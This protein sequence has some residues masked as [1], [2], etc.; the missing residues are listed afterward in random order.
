M[1]KSK[2]S[3][4]EQYL[5]VKRHWNGRGEG[6]LNV[7]QANKILRSLIYSGDIP[8]SLREAAKRLQEDIIM[9]NKSPK[10]QQTH[11]ARVALSAFLELLGEISPTAMSQ[12]VDAGITDNLVGTSF[13]LKL[14]PEGNTIYGK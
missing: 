13:T 5:Y 4:L 2:I 11:E 1:A 8:K 14:D 12:L 9:H 6:N 3:K 7:S 10:S